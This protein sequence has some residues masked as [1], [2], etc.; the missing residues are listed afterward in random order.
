MLACRLQMYSFIGHRPAASKSS[1][2]HDHSHPPSLTR[3]SDIPEILLATLFWN[4]PITFII[5]SVTIQISI[6]K[7]NAVCTT[8]LYIIIYA[9]T[10]APAFTNTFGTIP[11]RRCVLLRFK[12][13]TAYSLLLKMIVRTKY[14]KVS[15][16]SI[17]YKLAWINT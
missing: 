7:S 15:I 17:S 9:R 13:R 5:A 2:T 11:H 3:R 8:A 14:G 4:P 6:L 12:Y 16:V 1:A 10:V